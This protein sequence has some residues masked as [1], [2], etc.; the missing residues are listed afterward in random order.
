MGFVHGLPVGLSFFAEA[1][2]EP[3]LIGLTYAFEQYTKHRKPPEFIPTFD[4][5]TKSQ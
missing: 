4:F 3:K 5:T 1:F 2:S